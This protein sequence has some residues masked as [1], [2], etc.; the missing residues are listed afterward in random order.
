MVTAVIPPS[1]H[2]TAT[3][4]Q[5]TPFA[6]AIGQ[7]QTNGQR[8]S[9]FPNQE[10]DMYEDSNAQG[11]VLDYPQFPGALTYTMNNCWWNGE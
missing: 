2:R 3:S 9:V 1:Q 11:D 7:T 8:A 10:V 6:H 5:V 4:H